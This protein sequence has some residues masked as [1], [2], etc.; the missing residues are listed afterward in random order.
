VPIAGRCTRPAGFSRRLSQHPL[1][2]FFEKGDHLP[3]RYGRKSFEKI[4]DRLSTFQVVDQRLDR[5][6]KE[7]T[8]LR[9][10]ECGDHG[11]FATNF[12]G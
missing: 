3:A 12:H 5:N 1:F 10:S 8:E 4:V 7:R 6:A 2:G 9:N 11:F